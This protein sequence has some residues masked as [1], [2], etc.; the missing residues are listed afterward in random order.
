VGTGGWGYLIARQLRRRP[1]ELAG[2]QAALEAL[3]TEIEY[4]ATPLPAALR[5]AA[6]GCRGPAA[7]LCRLAAE[8][9]DAGGGASAGEAWAV[10]LRETDGLSA[11]DGSDLAALGQLGG[12][13]GGSGTTDQ[14]RHISLCLGRLRAAEAEARTGLER[15]ARMWLYLGILAGAALVL[16]TL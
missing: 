1:D 14:V 11:W 15:Q 8:H 9:L 10:A 6:L 3:R 7:A 16:A 12:A 13:L 5:R 2:A 4:A